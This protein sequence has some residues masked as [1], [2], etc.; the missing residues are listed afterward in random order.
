MLT[1]GNC[2]KSLHSK[3]AV[4]LWNDRYIGGEWRVLSLIVSHQACDNGEFEN[5]SGAT[6]GEDWDA[7]EHGRKMFI[8][9]V[10]VMEEHERLLDELIE[11]R[12]RD[13][14]KD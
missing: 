12:K 6:Y 11:Q 14:G 13:H 5:S 1:C 8:G 2:G 7:D 9:R 3:D 10:F 4:I